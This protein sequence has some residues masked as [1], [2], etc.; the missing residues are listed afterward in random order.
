GLHRLR[1]E[2]PKFGKETAASAVD[3]RPKPRQ[4]ALISVARG[5]R[6]GCLERD[7]RLDFGASMT[8]GGPVLTEQQKQYL[9][10]FLAAAKNRG[11]GAPAMPAAATP[12]PTGPEAI[13]AAAQDRVTA[14]GGKLVPEELAKRTKPPFDMWGEMRANAAA[15]RFPKGTDVFLHKFHGLFYVAPAQDSFMLRLRL[16]GGLIDAHQL[17]GL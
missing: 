1:A 9:E 17:R 8:D 2:R 10:G 3:K 15:K 4:A 7:N 14:A 6:R 11:A 13:H 5:L 12:Q 16:C